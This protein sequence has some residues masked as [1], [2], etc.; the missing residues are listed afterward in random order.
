VRTFGIVPR[1][2]FEQFSPERFSPRGQQEQPSEALFARKTTD[3]E[4]RD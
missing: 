1:G 4:A 2:E 3:Y